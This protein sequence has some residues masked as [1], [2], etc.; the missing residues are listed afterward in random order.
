[1]RKKYVAVVLL[2]SLLLSG[3]LVGCSLFS[4]EDTPPE[5]NLQ[6]QEEEQNEGNEEV[7][8]PYVA[9]HDDEGT[10][11]TV[12]EENDPRVMEAK[13]AILEIVEAFENFDYRTTTVEENIYPYLCSEALYYEL[14]NKEWEKAVAKYREAE[15]VIK[16]VSADIESLIF[17]DDYSTVEATVRSTSDCVSVKKELAT[18][19]EWALGEDTHRVRMVFYNDNGKWRFMASG[20]AE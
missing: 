17:L 11:Y 10:D 18:K 6:Q 13:A 19:D 16:F 4:K 7:A 2:F 12:L 3:L 1:M 9:W 20:N 15:A 5:G 8:E 14:E